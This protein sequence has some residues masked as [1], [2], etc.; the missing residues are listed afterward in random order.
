LLRALSSKE[1]ASGHCL[2]R[3]AIQI[4]IVPSIS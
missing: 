1:I 2:F 4:R 3:P